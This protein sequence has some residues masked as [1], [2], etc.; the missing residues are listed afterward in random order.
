M[1]QSGGICN[2]G[3]NAQGNAGGL[4]SARFDRLRV[5]YERYK[6]VSHTLPDGRTQWYEV[7][8]LPKGGVN[9]VQAKAVAERAGGYLVTFHSREENLFVFN[10][11]KDERFWFKWDSSHN[12]VMNG[13]F[14][15]AFQPDGARE[16]SGG[17]TWVSGEPMTYENWAYD[18]QPGDRD[19]R[20]NYQPND[21]MGNSN[22]AAFG[23][24]NDPTP[25]WGD[26]PH[27]FSSYRDS[28]DNKGGPSG[29]K[30][31]AHGFIIE[32]D[33]QP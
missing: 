28:F 3:L 13:P 9:W 31:A 20:P 1:G 26:F 18:G 25:S 11:I 23:E 12:Y 22:V 8:Y 4:D 5:R 17:W 16:P 21:S 32:Y 19:P 33:R 15:G 7:V 29:A 24:V 30:G 27:R 10:L 2:D 6:P 14:I